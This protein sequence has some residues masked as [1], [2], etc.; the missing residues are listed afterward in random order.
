M[1]F[2]YIIIIH[3]YSQLHY[4]EYSNCCAELCSIF[5]KYIANILMLHGNCRNKIIEHNL[6][7]L[8][9]A[10]N[11]QFTAFVNIFCQTRKWLI[12]RQIDQITDTYSITI[13]NISLPLCLTIALTFF[14]YRLFNHNT[15]NSS[16][17]S[18]KKKIAFTF[19]IIRSCV[20]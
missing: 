18:V 13:R 19:S 4:Q 3:N 14:V 15:L 1:K 10:S 11:V 6:Q 12:S 20:C 16:R 7:L 5:D 9:N 17:N 8:C 2:T